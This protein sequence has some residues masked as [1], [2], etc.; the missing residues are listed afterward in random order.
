MELSSSRRTNDCGDLGSDRRVPWRRSASFEIRRGGSGAR[1]EP[2]AL[3]PRCRSKNGHLRRDHSRCRCRQGDGRS[4]VV[5]LTLQGRHGVGHLAGAPFQIEQ[6]ALGTSAFA[7]RHPALAHVL[8][9]CPELVEDRAHRRP[10]RRGGRDDRER[11]VDARESDPGPEGH[12]YVL[13]PGRKPSKEA[14]L[15][16]RRREVCAPRERGRLRWVS[17]EG[18]VEAATARSRPAAGREA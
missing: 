14:G 8:L 5:A 9:G 13:S 3:V 2:L 16:A 12:G 11:Q 10:E 1:K 18:W 4:V 6:R 7:L 17:R 15:I